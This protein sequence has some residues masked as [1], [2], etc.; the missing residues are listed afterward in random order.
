MRRLP[1][2]ARV[3]FDAVAESPEGD[4][5]AE[6]WGDGQSGATG[7]SY[8]N[9]TSYLTIFGGWRNTKHVLARLD[10][11]GDDRLELD[12]DPNSDDEAACAP[13]AP[14]RDSRA[15]HRASRTGT[16]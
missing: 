5:K 4:I 2:N 1:V 8:S 12:V 13:P 15:S 16:R 14:G 10:E 3:E 6:L 11:H 7:S 9:A